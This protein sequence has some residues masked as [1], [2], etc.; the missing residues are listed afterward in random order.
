MCIIYTELGLTLFY[1]VVLLASSI[2]MSMS[3]N[4]PKTQFPI[5]MSKA[6][7]LWAL[8]Y[9][10]LRFLRFF[11][12]INKLCG[13]NF[14]AINSKRCVNWMCMDVHVTLLHYTH[15]RTCR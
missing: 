15:R 12:L 8:L 11:L 1:T 13:R 7:R 14:L 4:V 2:Q 5:F 6:H 3:T 10:N 9:G